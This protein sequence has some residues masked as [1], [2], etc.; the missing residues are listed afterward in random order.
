MDRTGEKPVSVTL[1]PFAKEDFGRLISWVSSER[2][3]VEWCAAF[4]R[5]PLDEAQLE[6]YL[7]SSKQPNGRAIFVAETADG[8][9]VGHGEIS[10]L[11][12]HLSSRLS[13]V[14]VAPSQRRRGI[15]TSLVARA[16]DFTFTEH[17]VDRIDLG[18]SKD[19]GAA[20]AC[21]GKLGFR[22]VGTWP[23]AIQ[24]AIKPIDVYWMT[25]T[26]ARWAGKATP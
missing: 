22:H 7:E 5:Y 20:I 4:F 6:R 25:L 23:K 10:H 14:L 2:S 13:R 9:A 1:R 24:T 18:V 19:N 3:H 16:L 26:K 21:Y 8:D 17:G 12:P 11:W 15:G